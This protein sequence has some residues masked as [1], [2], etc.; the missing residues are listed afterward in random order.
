MQYTELIWDRY[1]DSFDSELAELWN[2]MGSRLLEAAPSA[3]IAVLKKTILD[4]SYSGRFMLMRILQARAGSEGGF[5]YSVNGECFS[6]TDISADHASSMSTEESR[7]YEQVLEDIALRH[8]SETDYSR[9]LIV[10][11][12]HTPESYADELEQE[13]G[14]AKAKKLAK[15]MYRTRLTRQE[16]FDLGHILGFTLDEMQQF[17]LRVF[18]TDECFRF[19]R[20]EDIIEA[21]VFLTGGDIDA[22]AKLK[23]EY[24]RLSRG[25]EKDLSARKAG[26]TEQAP[27][28][29][30]EQVGEWMH[31]P[32]DRDERFMAWLLDNAP[33]L[34]VPSRSAGIIYRNLLAF[35][36]RFSDDT[37]EGDDSLELSQLTALLDGELSED[38]K[39]MIP[40]DK[41]LLDKRFSDELLG[42]IVECRNRYL[43]TFAVSANKNM[44]LSSA[45]TTAAFKKHVY[46]ILCGRAEVEKSDMLYLLWI[47]SGLCWCFEATD[48]SVTF[49][50][51][52]DF[53][54]VSE[55]FLKAAN[56]PEL[57]YPHIMESSIF[58]S[59]VSSTDEYDPS[60]TYAMICDEIKKKKS[61]PIRRNKSY[62]DE[63]KLAIVK[64]WIARKK[65]VS[66]DDFAKEYD[67]S[68]KTVSYWQKKLRDAGE[69]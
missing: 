50:H 66:L 21:Y 29:L 19:T 44:E 17:L 46:D 47:A 53:Q 24:G 38:A 39:K 36:C 26:W 57:Y 69:I 4:F 43:G 32:D 22:A 62:N 9:C 63:E 10:K 13:V 37:Y 2:L 14:A 11:A 54:G 18:D 35:I 23:E 6:F 67:I 1:L 20:S 30:D 45:D 27:A 7:R 40:D 55:E 8:E 15:E 5:E 65:T 3:R 34:D 42:T 56:L 68:P 52:C 33:H 28:A 51:L 49:E 48:G 58:L 41:M 60:E 61:E 64:D 59:I 31:R 25:I 16:A 12:W